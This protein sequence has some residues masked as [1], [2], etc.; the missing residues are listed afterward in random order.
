MKS[1]LLIKEKQRLAA[2]LYQ[3]RNELGIKQTDL[4]KE[5]IISQSQLSKIENAESNI[6]AV[7]LNVLA[8]RY[9]KDLSYF[10]E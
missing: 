1:N 5:G 3:T 9:G 2:K 10:F 8:K 7:L 4:A 6:S